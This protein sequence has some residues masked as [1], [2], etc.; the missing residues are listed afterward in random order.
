M[1]LINRALQRAEEEKR[2]REDR[3]PVVRP[4]PLTPS[5]V[6][7]PRDGRNRRP[8]DRPQRPRSGL[9]AAILMGAVVVA[10]AGV[11]TC[12][13]MSGDVQDPTTGAPQQA[14]A[15]AQPAQ[16]TALRHQPQAVTPPEPEKVLPPVEP[17]VAQPPAAVEP[18]KLEPEAVRPT[19]Q[20]PQPAPPVAEP[21]P[22]KAED[23]RLGAILRSDGSAHVLINEQMLTI[24]DMIDGAEV[25]A[26]EKHHVVLEKDGRRLVLRM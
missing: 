17:P 6:D 3:P 23:F 1:S 4:E 21:P 15:Q 20:E 5:P 9:R 26:I 12:L 24:G 8:G 2:R 18:A 11:V 14:M 10:A 7:S 22:L 16:P 13:S 25:M 19:P